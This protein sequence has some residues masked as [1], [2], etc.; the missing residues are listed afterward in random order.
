MIK[1][2][3]IFLLILATIGIADAKEYETKSGYHIYN[4]RL[5]KVEV[6]NQYYVSFSARLKGGP[7]CNNLFIQVVCTTHTG[8]YLTLE[9]KLSKAGGYTS[10]II[11]IKVSLQNLNTAPWKMI[12]LS[13]PELACLGEP[14]TASIIRHLYKNDEDEVSTAKPDFYETKITY[15][16]SGGEVLHVRL[17]Q[18]TSFDPEEWYILRINTHCIPDA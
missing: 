4:A 11:G 12:D 18:P 17:A 13:D 2:I 16:E 5:E 1:S 10:K 7:K 3:F 14:D 8:E 9:T 6:R 15:N